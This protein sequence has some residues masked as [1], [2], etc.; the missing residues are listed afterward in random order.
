[1]I[2]II[3]FSSIAVILT[4]IFTFFAGIPAL[5]AASKAGLIVLALWGTFSLIQKINLIVK[6]VE[7]FNSCVAAIHKKLKK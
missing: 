2:P 4:G 6:V 5:I 1:M 7:I 3:A